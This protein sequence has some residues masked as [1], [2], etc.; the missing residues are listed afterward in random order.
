MHGGLG[1]LVKMW[2][3]M[4]AA[5]RRTAV[6]LINP[7]AEPQ[8][9]GAG[10]Q[11]GP[12]AAGTATGGTLLYQPA[13]GVSDS[14]YNS[15]LG[16][17]IIHTQECSTLG[18]AGDI[19]FASL[20]QYAIFMR[21]GGLRADASIHVWFDQGVTAF[22]FQLRVTGHPWWSTPL[23][24]KNGSNTRSAFIALETRA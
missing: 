8:L 10:L 1:N 19:V 20:P 24:D 12:A 21:D 16:R 23:A 14:P 18:T 9:M 4:P 13:G 7:D 17:P 22:R 15:L 11:V 3:R 5:W 2:S 6:W